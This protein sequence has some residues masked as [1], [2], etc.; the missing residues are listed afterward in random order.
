MNDARRRRIELKKRIEAQRKIRE[1]KF[2]E[3]TDTGSCVHD[4]PFRKR[5]P[6]CEAILEEEYQ[7]ILRHP[8][9]MENILKN[10]LGLNETRP[11]IVFIRPHHIGGIMFPVQISLSAHNPTEQ[12]MTMRKNGFWAVDHGFLTWFGPEL[13]QEVSFLNE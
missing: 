12:I 2:F 9:V 13:I 10:K 5:C 7:K 6:E 4:I 1:T 11:A 8:D 3:F